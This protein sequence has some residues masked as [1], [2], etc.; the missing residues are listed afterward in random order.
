MEFAKLRFYWVFVSTPSIHAKSMRPVGSLQFEIFHFSYYD[1]NFIFDMLNYFP[2]LGWR[3]PETGGRLIPVGCR[4][5]SLVR[6]RVSFYA[7][8]LPRLPNYSAHVVSDTSPAFI[9]VVWRHF[10]G[11]E[12]GKTQR[13]RA[14]V[15]PSLQGVLSPRDRAEPCPAPIHTLFVFLW[16]SSL[17]LKVILPEAYKVLLY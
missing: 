13:D 14:R 7:P 6:T 12:A 17:D 15:M 5:D 9:A 3:L 1:I 16:Q 4:A 10:C 11:R 2:K 8:L